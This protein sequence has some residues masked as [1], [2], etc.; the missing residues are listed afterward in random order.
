MA[1]ATW[2]GEVIA[3]SDQGILVPGKAI[4]PTMIL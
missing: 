3:E 1:K 2:N 4:Q